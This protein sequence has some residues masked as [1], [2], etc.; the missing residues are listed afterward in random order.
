MSPKQKLE[1]SAPEGTKPKGFTL[2]EVL[3]VVAIIGILASVVIYAINPG[4]QLA[5]SR[6]SQRQV[7]TN[8]ILKAAYQYSI[9]HNGA[10]PAGIDQNLRVIGTDTTGCN[11][12]CG[13][14]MALDTIETPLLAE[15][16]MSHNVLNSLIDTAQAA[17]ASGWVLPDGDQD[18]GNQWSNR[19]NA[20][21]NNLTT[22]ASNNYGGTGWGQYIVFTLNTPIYSNRVRI[23]TDYLDAQIAGVQVDVNMNGSW[24]T[25]YTGGSQALWNDTWVEIPF[26]AGTVSQARFRYNYLA[27]GYY[28]WMYEFQ[29]YKT[30]PSVIPP[31]VTTQNAD[32]VQDVAATTHGTVADDGGEPCQ[33]RFEYGTTPAYGQTTAWSGSVASG[34]N[35]NDFFN[36]LTPS[37]TYHFRAALRNSAGTSYGADTTF[38]TTAPL[39]GWVSPSGFSDPDGAWTN[40]ALA[41]DQNIATYAASYH[42][43]G[44]PT[45]SS[46]LYLTHSDIISG[47]LQFF[48]RGGSEV[49]TVQVDVYVD[50]TWTTAYNGSFAGGQWVTIPFTQGHLT[51][52]RFRFAAT[53]NSGFFFQL[54]DV[55]FQKSSEGAATACLDLGALA[56]NYVVG[57]PVDPTL[58]T[59]QKTYYGIKEDGNNRLTVYACN[60]EL[61]DTIAVNN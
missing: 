37:T 22:Y 39:I 51:Q 20:Y 18:P 40:A 24:V 31:S 13:R 36:G 19:T 58:G 6:N 60:P 4:R 38:T 17:P 8:T 32:L 46:Y 33:Y 57:I 9:D 29:F 44:G 25:I 10:M 11:I 61:G 48:A 53:A 27:G 26:T 43:I 54:N 5:Q 49:N 45:W 55:L 34:D 59:P 16:R 56:P 3:L 28:Y 1:K 41:T 14:Q 7:D 21:D 12:A 42:A 2:L 47:K 52:A 50:G 15:N 23:N 35:F 30:V